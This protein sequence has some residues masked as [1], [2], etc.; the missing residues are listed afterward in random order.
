MRVDLPPYACSCPANWT[1][2]NCERTK[3][4]KGM[5]VSTKVLVGVGVIGAVVAIGAVAAAAGAAWC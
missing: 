2:T 4:I 3:E 5:P 1:G